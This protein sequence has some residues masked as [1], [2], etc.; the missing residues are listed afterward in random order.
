MESKYFHA[1]ATYSIISAT[2]SVSVWS[3]FATKICTD[4][5]P[6]YRGRN[7]RVVAPAR[8]HRDSAIGTIGR[9]M[10][11]EHAG[12]VQPKELMELPR[13]TRR[14]RSPKGWQVFEQVLSGGTA[15]RRRTDAPPRAL[16]G[17]S[18]W[19]RMMSGERTCRML[20]DLKHNVPVAILMAWS[21][22]FQFARTHAMAG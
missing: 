19:L 17:D 18:L 6:D 7:Q 11:G 8:W 21:T 15:D 12:H 20:R 13:L 14:S 10:H 16:I 4:Q 2:T 5:R 22:L 3:H 1:L 9:D